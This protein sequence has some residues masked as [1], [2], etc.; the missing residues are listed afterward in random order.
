MCSDRTA[1]FSS[2]GM[3]TSPNATEPFQLVAMPPSPRG[4][5]ARESKR[6]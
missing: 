1:D 3:F 5:L 4:G 6:A 2:T